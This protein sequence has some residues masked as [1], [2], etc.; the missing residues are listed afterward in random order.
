MLWCSANRYLRVAG[1]DYGQASR[2]ARP[3]DSQTVF[4]A[5]FRIPVLEQRLL[6]DRWLDHTEHCLNRE[7]IK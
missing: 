5:L 3:R 1:S 7:P 4:F 6:Y 2:S